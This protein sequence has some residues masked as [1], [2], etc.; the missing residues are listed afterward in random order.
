MHPVNFYTR[1]VNCTRFELNEWKER[2]DF[3]K[4][5]LGLT[6]TR[7]LM[8]GTLENLFKTVGV[9]IR[10]RPYLRH[11]ILKGI[12]EDIATVSLKQFGPTH[13]PSEDHK[14]GDEN[15]D[16]NTIHPKVLEVLLKNNILDPNHTQKDYPLDGY[17]ICFQD[18]LTRINDPAVIDQ[19]LN[20]VLLELITPCK[21]KE[22]MMDHRGLTGSHYSFCKGKVVGDDTYHCRK[23]KLCAGLDHWHSRSH[24]KSAEPPVT[25]EEKKFLYPI[26]LSG[27]LLATHTDRPTLIDVSGNASGVDDM[28]EPVWPNPKCVPDAVESDWKDLRK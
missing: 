12:P 27:K 13:N 11:K 6:Y 5:N 7:Y 4:N 22:Y 24:K 16:E 28:D 2:D 20:S 23:C 26:P 1:R 3:T 10:F 18:F 17:D 15:D 9:L 19:C 14:N 21:V 8:C 25:Q